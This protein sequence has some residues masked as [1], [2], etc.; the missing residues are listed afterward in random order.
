MMENNTD[1]GFRLFTIFAM[2]PAFAL[3]LPYGMNSEGT[4]C[5]TIGLVPMAFSACT[6]VVHVM[7]KA[8]SRAGNTVMD[9]FCA[10]FL[11]SIL[12]P[13]WIDMAARDF[14]RN[15]NGV[16]MLGTYGT[17]PMMFNFIIHAWFVLRELRWS[18]LF[19]RKTCPHCNCSLSRSDRQ[20]HRE[21]QHVAT[22]ETGAGGDSKERSVSVHF[23][24]EEQ[25]G[26][27]VSIDARPS[28]DDE[29]ARLL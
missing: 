28:T 29:S 17:V 21:Y 3:L 18:G 2:A 1:R 7:G 10:C 23:V 22:E 24:D 26:P 14:S 5:P 8:K 20:A 27:S 4:I 15:H 19:T 13:G 6:G 25:G 9:L 16:T 11:I 12:M